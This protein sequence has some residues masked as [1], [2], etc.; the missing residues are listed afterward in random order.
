MENKNNK[1]LSGSHKAENHKQKDLIPLW[2]QGLREHEDEDTSPLEVAETPGDSW[3]NEISAK[4]AEEQHPG[5]DQPLETAAEPTGGI[6]TKPELLDE[7]STIDQHYE[8]PSPMQVEARNSSSALTDEHQEEDRKETPA[9]KIHDE[10]EAPLEDLPSFEDEIPYIVPNE[11]E[12][13]DTVEEGAPEQ[14][15]QDEDLP[16]WLQEMIAEP[17]PS[18]DDQRLDQE[19]QIQKEPAE[20]IDEPTEPIILSGEPSNQEKIGKIEEKEIV[21]TESIEEEDDEIYAKEA[22]SL[23]KESLDVQDDH[24]IIIAQ[25]ENQPSKEL[26]QIDASFQ[27]EPP[28]SQWVPEQVAVEP[29]GNEKEPPQTDT[30]ASG[31][32]ATTHPV[33]IAE[34]SSG[35][36]EAPSL[37]ES[38]VSIP[39]SL[40]KEG[41]QAEKSSPR[42]PEELIRAK[43]M[44]VSGETDEAVRLIRNL[45]ERSTYSQEI[46]TWLTDT[47]ND[48]EEPNVG[49]WELLGDIALEDEQPDI[50]LDAY[51]HAIQSL[52]INQEE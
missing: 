49:F 2:L 34:E 24:E 21:F 51:A 32:E 19:E 36:V 3:V 8:E 31:K 16:P 1:N 22:I 30:P 13:T 52:L 29:I 35:E 50:A 37:E 10:V 12:I 5:I 41:D 46:K 39:E 11:V 20:K 14:F 9:E 42:L 18:L 45:D 17:Q 43:E 15:S 27:P 28:P 47:A 6:E 33:D 7:S 40:Q 25:E 38:A 4:T 44:L 26:D 23:E 48:I